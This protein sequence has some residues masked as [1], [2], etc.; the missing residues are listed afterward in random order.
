MA[1]RTRRRKPRVVWLPQDPFF[2]ADA[3]T[4]AHSTVMRA[5]DT[6][7]APNVAGST[8]SIVAPCV[9][10]VP[11]NPLTAAATLA[12]I[13]SSGYRLRRIVGKIWYGIS[14]INEADGSNVGA[15]VLTAGF[16][17]LRSDDLGIPI[18]PTANDQYNANIIE[19]TESPWIWRRSWLCGSASPPDNATMMS[20]T[21]ARGVVT[22]QNNV[23]RG[24]VADG[25]HVDQKTARLIGPDERL[26]L[27][28]S[29]TV[30]DASPSANDI[31]NVDWVWDCRYLASMRT[32]IG[33]RRNASR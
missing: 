17:V 5:Q 28:L 32:M 27:V 6:L 30:I 3:N 9:R 13:Q 7:A 26:F 33:N 31:T 20:I 10:D 2:S 22:F 24:G 19:N 29:S 8:Q 21:T 23:N 4:L 16:I 18:A 11:I 25:P 14:G 15:V 1:F 12:D